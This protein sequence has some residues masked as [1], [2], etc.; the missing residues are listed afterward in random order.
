[1]SETIDQSIKFLHLRAANKD[2]TISSF[3]G[4]T[5]AYRLDQANN[6]IHYAVACVNKKDRYMK[7]IGRPLAAERLNAFTDET[8]CGTVTLNDIA[9]T[10]MHRLS[11]EGI[12]KLNVVDFDWFVTKEAVIGVVT[13]DERFAKLSKMFF[14]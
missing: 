14:S 12:A 6:V 13:S 10:Y 7:K 2:F 3:G 11:P 1:M 4:L 9:A 8:K 5:V